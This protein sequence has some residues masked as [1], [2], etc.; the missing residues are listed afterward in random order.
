MI[1]VVLSGPP[2]VRI[3]VRNL[4]PDEAWLVGVIDGS[5]H[6]I[7]FPHYRPSITRDGVVVARPETAEDPLVG[8]L[9][10]QDFRR[11]GPG[12]SFDPTGP[13]FLPLA[14]FA[15]P[16]TE[17]GLYRY[18]LTVSTDSPSERDWLGRFGQDDAV[19][20]LVEQVPRFTVMSNVLEVRLTRG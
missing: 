17:P 14:T 2:P 13:G 20:T 1:A 10:E 15:T 7:R 11:L 12:E 6:G 18:S 19:L 8:P 5:E 9:R 16:L 4:G 3:E